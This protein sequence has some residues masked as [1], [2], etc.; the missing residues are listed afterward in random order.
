MAK[1]QETEIKK[2]TGE[3]EVAK[4]ELEDFKIDTEDVIAELKNQIQ[5][6]DKQN[7]EEREKRKIEEE[8]A[9]KQKE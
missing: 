5:G 8:E 4:K 7:E 2:L 1:D 3:C 6:R 9:A